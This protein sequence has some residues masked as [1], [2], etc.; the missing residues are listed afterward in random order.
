MHNNY[1]SKYIFDKMVLYIFL[2]YLLHK[3]WNNVNMFTY[4]IS[5]NVLVF[6]NVFFFGQ[7]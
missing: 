7:L 5:R 4:L 1:P 2:K 6:M 3:Y